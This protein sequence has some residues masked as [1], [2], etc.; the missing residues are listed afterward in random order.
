MRSEDSLVAV[1]ASKGGWP[2]KLD[3]ELTAVPFIRMIL[4][5]PADIVSGVRDD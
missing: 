2:P 1:Q 4:P 5:T 3:A